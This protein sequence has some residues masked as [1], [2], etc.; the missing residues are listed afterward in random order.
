MPRRALI[1]LALFASTAVA[2]PVAPV[3]DIGLRHDIQVLADYGAISGPRY[4]LA[5]FLGCTCG[6]SAG[7]GRQQDNPARCSPTNHGS[8]ARTCQT[9]DAAA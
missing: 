5:A 9:R 6:G 1:V 7:L 2:G 4:H 8:N 3:G